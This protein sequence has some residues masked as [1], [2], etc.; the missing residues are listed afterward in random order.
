MFFEC[1]AI[2]SKLVIYHA[3]YQVQFNRRPSKNASVALTQREGWPLYFNS[4]SHIS[5]N[6]SPQIS[7]LECGIQES[8]QMSVAAFRT[9]CR[10]LLDRE[11]DRQKDRQSRWGRD[12]C[13]CCD[14]RFPQ[15][16]EGYAK[17]WLISNP[18]DTHTARYLNEAVYQSKGVNDNM[19]CD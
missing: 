7:I 5:N 3:N 10:L 13:K 19:M 9:G 17:Y 4:V 18:S 15:K 14:D 12:N 2:Q 6:V 16:W 11:T 1:R 8:N